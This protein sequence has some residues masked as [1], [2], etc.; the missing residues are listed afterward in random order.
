MRLTRVAPAETAFIRWCFW[1]VLFGESFFVP[2]VMWIRLVLADRSVEVF[3]RFRIALLAAYL[4]L[5]VVVP[6]YGMALAVLK[7]IDHHASV[8]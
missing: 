6:I 7:Q 1:C 3:G 4:A 5:F 8:S 2:G